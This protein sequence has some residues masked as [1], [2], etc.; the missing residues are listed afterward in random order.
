MRIP[1]GLPKRAE[2][3]AGFSL[4]AL[5][6]MAADLLAEDPAIAAAMGEGPPVA[7]EKEGK[8]ERL[9]R[10]RSQDPK[11][12]ERPALLIRSRGPS[13]ARDGGDAEM[14]PTEAEYGRSCLL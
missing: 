12:P 6:A 5:Q 3:D 2:E 1:T 10:T 8:K 9:E 13:P 7:K 11:E 4:E 14:G